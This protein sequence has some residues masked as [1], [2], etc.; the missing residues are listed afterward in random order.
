M[1]TNGVTLHEA[2]RQLGVSVATVRRYAKAGKLP[3]SLVEGVY[4]PEYRVRIPAE[5]ML[6]RPVPPAGMPTV[7]Q[8]MEKIDTLNQEVG[9]WRARAQVAEERV[10]LLGAPKP[11]WWQRLGIRSRASDAEKPPHD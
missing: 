2:A 11:H 9:Y 4:G 5:L 1:D 8:L 10:L 7:G 6:S 3:A